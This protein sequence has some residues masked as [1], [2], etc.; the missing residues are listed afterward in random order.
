MNTNWDG[1]IVDFYSNDT[2]NDRRNIFKYVHNIYYLAL[3]MKFEIIIIGKKS[4]KKFSHQIIIFVSMRPNIIGCLEYIAKALR[5]E[6][7]I[8]ALNN[9]ENCSGEILISMKTYLK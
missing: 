8:F 1:N 9:S 5:N 7:T 2:F 3:E 6:R 4:V